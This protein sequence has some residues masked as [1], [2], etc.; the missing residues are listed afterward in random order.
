M[1]LLENENKIQ[2]LSSGQ[3]RSEGEWI[4]PKRVI[5]SNEIIFV[6][7]GSVFIC[8]ENKQYEL[9][10]NDFLILEKD[11]E[12]Y[13]FEASSDV[14]FYWLHFLC[15]DFEKLPKTGN[16]ASPLSLT[17]L[18]TQLLHFTNT[19]GYSEN[20]GD[21][22]CGLILEEIM[23]LSNPVS[24]KV[25]QLA[26]NLKEWARINTDKIVSVKNAGEKFGY[27]EDY[28]NRIFKQ[29]YGITLK[30]YIINLKLE[31]AKILL[32]TTLYTV[33]QIALSLGYRDEN[34]FIKFFVYHEKTTPTSYRNIYTNTHTNK[35]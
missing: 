28:L 34:L 30:Q 8:E 27:S 9:T 15:G 17:T 11:R 3:F 5:D 6:Q 10:K 21:M 2:Y 13:G 29:A 23:F 26:T 7:K 35:H 22:L 31:K 25:K 32:Q 16:T 19:P 24:K 14:S 12:H 20:C 18:F 1:I 4:H 33:K